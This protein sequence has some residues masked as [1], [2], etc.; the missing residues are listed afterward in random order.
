MKPGF[1]VLQKDG[2]KCPT[3]IFLRFIQLK[4]GS[5][6]QIKSCLNRLNPQ[7]TAEAHLEK[8]VSDIADLTFYAWH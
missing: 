5:A 2:V 8:F 1:L 3:E 6:A 4:G 7:K